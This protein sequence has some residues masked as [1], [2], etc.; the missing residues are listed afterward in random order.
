[1]SAITAY[2]LV[3][4]RRFLERRH[5]LQP[6]ARARLAAELAERLRPKV[7][8]APPGSTPEEFLEDLATAKASRA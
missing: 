2:E 4:V 3:T 7:L 1:M 8:G 5:D 6:A